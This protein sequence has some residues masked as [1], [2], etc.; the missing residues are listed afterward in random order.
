MVWVPSI[1]GQPGIA[2]MDVYDP[3]TG[4]RIGG[5]PVFIKDL[6][7]RRLW[8][9]T[10]TFTVNL[11]AGNPRSVELVTN[12]RIVAIYTNFR[13]IQRSVLSGV[14]ETRRI[15]WARDEYV[16]EIN[17]VDLLSELG[18]K[19][20]LLGKT[21]TD[22]TL[23]V[24]VEDMISRVTGWSITVDPEVANTYITS[25]YSGMNVL[26]ALRKITAG[27]GIHFRKT[28]PINERVIEVGGFQNTK[29][30]YGLQP[31]AGGQ[32]LNL[33]T[34]LII[35]RVTVTS[36][37]EQVVNWIIPYGDVLLLNDNTKD[38]S[39]TLLDLS[40]TYSHVWDVPPYNGQFPLFSYDNDGTF[41][42]GMS[43]AASIR[44]YGQFEALV[45]FPISNPYSSDVT[46]FQRQREASSRQLG[47]M[48]AAWLERTS[49]ARVTY[50]LRAWSPNY[51]VV[52]PGDH[53]NLR[54]KGLAQDMAGGVIELLD[55]DDTFWIVDVSETVGT[56][57]NIL[58][59]QVSNVD[60]PV[61]SLPKRIV[62]TMEAVQ[63]IQINGV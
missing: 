54:Y 29:V 45:K 17:G 16:L 4:G 10:G 38:P 15:R 18:R 9:G 19:N 39:G 57:G 14:V 47:M 6:S 51:G 34:N 20:L 60:Q 11:S 62:D 30:W 35:D 22:T 56:E 40:W 63:Y 7:V 1:V 28:E 21:Y 46:E 59:L 48:A 8:D 44:Q 36:D 61:Q 5:G 31:T 50:S 58:E 42:Y 24:V 25:T 52:L 49:V 13:G 23:Q 12:K 3:F 32:T 33:A 55:I 27:I 2:F 41:M 43:N 37:S 53:F 26:Q